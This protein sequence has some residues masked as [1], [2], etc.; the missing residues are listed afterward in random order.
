MFG[1]LTKFKF[2]KFISYK[3]IYWKTVIPTNLYIFFMPYATKDKLNNCGRHCM[4]FKFSD[5]C[6]AFNIELANTYF[7]FSICDFQYCLYL[8]VLSISHELYSW[9]SLSYNIALFMI[10]FRCHE[11]IST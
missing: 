3:K 6:L 10:P 1:P 9:C 5:T 7:K 4:V 2:Y 8:P 11:S